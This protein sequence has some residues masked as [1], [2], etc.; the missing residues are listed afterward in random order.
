MR[1]GREC[2][3]KLLSTLQERLWSP[4]LL[5]LHLS[6]FWSSLPQFTSN[7][8]LSGLIRKKE[9]STMRTLTFGFAKRQAP[10]LLDLRLPAASSLLSSA[11][12]MRQ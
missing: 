11:I 9:E 2:G 5:P 3:E 7:I 1:S 4:C 10:I 12:R 6:L 8:N